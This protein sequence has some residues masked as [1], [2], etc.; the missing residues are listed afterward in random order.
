VYDMTKSLLKPMHLFP[1]SEDNLPCSQANA[2]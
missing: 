1:S 2:C